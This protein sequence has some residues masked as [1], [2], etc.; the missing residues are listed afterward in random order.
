ML[1]SI[2]EGFCLEGLLGAILFSELDMTAVVERV[3]VVGCWEKKSRGYPKSRANVRAEL[4][5]ALVGGSF[6]SRA[7][8]R[9]TSQYAVRYKPTW[10]DQEKQTPL[11]F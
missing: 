5:E 10:K 2:S 3:E 9:G 6:F 8:S 7:P 4:S 1:V 11:P